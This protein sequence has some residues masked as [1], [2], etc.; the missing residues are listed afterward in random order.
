MSTDCASEV[1]RHGLHEPAWWALNQGGRHV[2]DHIV[3]AY[4]QRP[5]ADRKPTAESHLG[6]AIA[7]TVE[8]ATAG[9]N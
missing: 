2:N 5:V 9:L 1:T 6:A 8:P 3:F 4:V 7:A